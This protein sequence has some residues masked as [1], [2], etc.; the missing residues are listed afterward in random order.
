VGDVAD[1]D[2]SIVWFGNATVFDEVFTVFLENLGVESEDDDADD[3]ADNG[4][5]KCTLF[6]R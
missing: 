1:G 6:R 2:A 3:I 5:V 4:G